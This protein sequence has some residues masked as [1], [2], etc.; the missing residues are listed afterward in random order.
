M[1]NCLT[2]Y[3]KETFNNDSLPYLDY[4]AISIDS[5]SGNGLSV[6]YDSPVKVK[7]TGTI[8][9]VDS[10][11]QPL[12]PAQ[13]VEVYTNNIRISAGK[14]KVLL[15]KYYMNT[16]NLSWNGEPVDMALNIEEVICYNTQNLQQINLDMGS[17]QNP[18]II[19]NLSKGNITATVVNLR[20][21]TSLKGNVLTIVSN[22][23]TT[24]NIG[25]TNLGFSTSEIVSK[26]GIQYLTINENVIGNISELGK[27]PA[28]TSLNF[29]KTNN[30]RSNII[31]K[32]V[33]FVS[34][35]I[36]ARKAAGGDGSGSLW[37]AY[38]RT[39]FPYVTWPSIITDSSAI[40]ASWDAS[41]NISVS[42]T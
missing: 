6:H 33:D 41:G 24:L 17:V 10:S 36:T 25:R 31:G 7:A 23:T 18:N 39:N 35:A 38:P 30:K 14:G 34:N 21:C 20:G 12:D 22:S 5:E 8:Q 19:G 16:F 40:T 27:L 13:E 37:L 42:T 11:S 9:F 1:E 4:V 32:F 29:I 15:P 28:I 3:L 2:T 26:V